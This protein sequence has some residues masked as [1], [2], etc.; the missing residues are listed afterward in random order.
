M[1]DVTQILTPNEQIA[2]QFDDETFTP[3]VDDGSAHS[4]S[5]GWWLI[6]GRRVFMFTARSLKPQTKD[7]TTQAEA[8]C[9][10]LELA[11]T[12]GAPLVALWGSDDLDMDR[13]LA[14]LALMG[15]L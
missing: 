14:G 10:A 7:I 2:A 9:R 1:P 5:V 15:D 4:A 8:I 3:I 13:S 11:C 6:N 12:S